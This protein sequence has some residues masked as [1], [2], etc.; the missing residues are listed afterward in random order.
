VTPSE[1]PTPA[2]VELPLGGR[3]I[4]PR[5][6][7]VAYYGTAGNPVLGV[8]GESSAEGIIRRLRTAAAPFASSGR[9]I[10]VA[11]E[12]IAIVAQAG[13]GKDGSYSRAIDFDDIRHYIEVAKRNKVLVVLDVQPGRIDFLTQVKR[14]R[15]FLQEPNVGLALDP[16]WRM[17]PGEIPGRTIG[18]VSAAE[19]NAVSAYVAQIVHDYDLPE[20]LFLLHEFRSSMIPDISKVARR[21][22]L[23]MVQHIDGFGTR[24]EKD[25]TFD[26][27]IR[28]RQF[29]I[30]YKLFYDEDIDL[31]TPRDVLRFRPTPEYVSYQ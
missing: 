8:L 2:G 4:F 17:W 31:Y 25:A 26:R 14:L 22:G 5:Y 7:V 28:P 6:R 23:A 18:H 1:T 3:T 13:P 9:T 27:L 19:V 20:K 15:P 16:E 30:G 12:L 24:S 11:Y 29:H 21:T 10:Q